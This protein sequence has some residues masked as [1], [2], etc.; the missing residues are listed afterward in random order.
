M[1]F[2]TIKIIG[3]FIIFLLCFPLHFLY[4]WLPNPIISIFTPVNE[5]I[6]EHMKLIYTSYM[7]YS[8]FE[9]LWLKKNNRDINNYLLQLF[10]VPLLGIIIYLIIYLPIYNV[11]G[12]NMFISIALL[13]IIIIIEQIISYYFLSYKETKFQNII[14]I[15][16]II[17]TYIAFGYFTYQPMENY[18]F[19]DISEN[20]Y[21]INIYTD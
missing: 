9:Y 1:S 6:A 8:I 15:L 7:I 14:G 4:D 5:S 2:K 19:Y 18:V 12:E 21:G 11:F 13:F 17:L 3:V 10:I 20:K 16:G